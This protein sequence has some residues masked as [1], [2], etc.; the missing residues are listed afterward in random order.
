MSSW[1]INKFPIQVEITRK[2]RPL[3]ELSIRNCQ[4]PF[5]SVV[6]MESTSTSVEDAVTNGSNNAGG[7]DAGGDDFWLWIK[8]SDGVA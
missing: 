2:R 7:D 8:S 3:M 6:A 4:S 5:C 1:K